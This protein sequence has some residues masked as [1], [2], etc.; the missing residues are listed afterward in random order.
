M[1]LDDG[2]DGALLD[3]YA[4]YEELQDG[5]DGIL[6]DAC[7]RIERP[8]I[9]EN[10]LHCVWNSE[11][12]IE[13]N[14][15]RAIVRLKDTRSGCKLRAATTELFFSVDEWPLFA[16]RILLSPDFS[17]TDRISLASFLHGN[18]LND[19]NFAIHIFKM[20]NSHWKD[21]HRWNQK[22]YKF[23]KLFEYLGRARMPI[24]E[25]DERIRSTYWYYD[26]NSNQT[27][28]YDESIRT[29]TGEKAPDSRH[30]YRSHRWWI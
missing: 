1:S 12:Q 2:N 27:V 29:P 18:G 20:Y 26:M 25:D 19:G 13:L 3:A 14:R 21:C 17:Y 5:N 10:M 28:F 24:T 15:I 22:F 9:P 23:S 6:F 4:L 8:S 16:L 7:A 30:V 11:K